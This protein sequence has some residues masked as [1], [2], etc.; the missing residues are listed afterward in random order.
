MFRRILIANRGEV[1]ARVARTASRL[2]IETVAVTSTAD[3]SQ[4]WLETV[5]RVVCIGPPRASQSYLDADAL[6]EVGRHEGCAAVHP[7]WGFLSENEHFAAR[8]EAAG[9]T[10]IGPS[11][12]HL[13]TMGDKS[14]AR[15]TMGALGMPL[16]PGSKEPVADAEH[17]LRVAEEVGY[18]I[19]LKAVAGGGG[20]GMRGVDRPE[21]LPA[22][23]EEASAEAIA[24]FGDGRMYL[25][26]RIVGGR[27]VEV[28]VLADAWGHAVVLGERECSLQ[29]RHQKVLEE[30]P[31]P[32]LAPDERARILPI[33]ADVVRRSGYRNAGTVEML[34][35]AS[36]KAYFMEMNTRLQVEHPVTE[37]IMG[38]DLVEWQLRV[39]AN[40]RLTLDQADLVPRGHA[41]E[42][43]IN[44]EDPDRSFRPS[45]GRVTT[46]ELP[47]G[48]GIRVDTHLAAGDR[49]PPH[50]DSMVAKVIAH[51]PDRRAAIERMKGALEATRIEGV[52][53]NIE[54]HKRILRW[55]AF[56]TGQ[57]DTTSL[58]SELVGKV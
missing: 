17:A 54:L 31:A 56:T 22:A 18:P 29:R 16:I 44:A 8:C 46:L 57:Y 28:Q 43:R 2:G 7:G 41:L 30:A 12:K 34:V 51:G 9:L 5:D 58:E 42:C 45:P 14:L 23:F 53:T 15:A 55:N 48:E 35:D 40:Q 4:A 47:T 37:E 6:I 21:D 19:L 13:R 3:S 20:R 1:A 27:H 36:G 39:A 38:V 50:Y 52:T 32:G 25:E 33:V 24:S 11:P 49:I 26:R 10:F